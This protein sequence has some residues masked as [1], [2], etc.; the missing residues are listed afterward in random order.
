MNNR[1][2]YSLGA[3]KILSVTLLLSLINTTSSQSCCESIKCNSIL[4]TDDTDKER[5]S[6]LLLLLAGEG[7][8]YVGTTMATA[9]SFD[10]GMP[11]CP[12]NL[13]YSRWR[14]SSNEVS[15]ETRSMIIEEL[16]AALIESGLL[17]IGDDME[18]EVGTSEMVG[19][20][21]HSNE[22]VS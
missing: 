16:C 1:N 3:S 2:G 15:L 21:R 20:G 4:S 22:L 11:S 8:V 10:R 13:L 9:N 7:A 19:E 17:E 12:T 6:L 5:D 14:M 18:G